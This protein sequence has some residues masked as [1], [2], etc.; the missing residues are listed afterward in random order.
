MK[1]FWMTMINKI[2]KL[3]SNPLLIYPYATSKGLTH[4]VPDK[5]HLALMYK[6]TIGKQL[7]LRSPKAFNEKLQW[8]KIYDRDPSHI[9]L[10]DKYSVKQWVSDRIGQEYVAKTFAKWDSVEEIDISRL[11][12]RFVLKTNHDCGGVV[13]CRDKESFDLV[14]AKRKLSRH[15]RRDYYWGG[16]EWPYRGVKRCIFAEELLGADQG[17]SVQG[18]FTDYKFMCFNGSVLCAFTCTGRESGDLRVDFFDNDWRHLP[19]ERHYP[20]ADRLPGA[21][22]NLRFMQDA[23]E[24]LADGI[25]FVRVDFYE[26][27]GRPYFGEMTF[28]PGSGFEEFTP[29]EWDRKMGDWL[30]LPKPRRGLAESNGGGARR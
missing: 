11:P 7:D 17:S 25:P 3:I 23:S 22:A 18:G 30:S 26:V 12:E 5:I 15:L 4:W 27:G 19:F 20:N 24:A 13:I 28:Y 16:R 14:G 2:K 6:A 29:E 21:P 1:L 8:L 10:V 9:K